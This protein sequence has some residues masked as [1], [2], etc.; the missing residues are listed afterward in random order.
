MQFSYG[1]SLSLTLVEKLQFDIDEA[2]T[3]LALCVT[4]CKISSHRINKTLFVEKG[5]TAW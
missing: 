2:Q 1:S 4:M 3:I 5:V